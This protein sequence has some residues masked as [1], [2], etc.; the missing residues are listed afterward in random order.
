MKLPPVVCF[1]SRKKLD[2]S[3]LDEFHPTEKRSW[4]FAHEDLAM[5]IYVARSIHPRG[6]LFLHMCRTVEMSSLG[7]ISLDGITVYYSRKSER[8][9]CRT[10][11][12]G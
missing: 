8:V 1:I 4:F 9:N 2:Y 6:V 12:I 10:K 11:L 7:C 5:G 3:P